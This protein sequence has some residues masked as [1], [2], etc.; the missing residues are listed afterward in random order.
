MMDSRTVGLAGRSGPRQTLAIGDSAGNA[1]LSFAVAEYLRLQYPRWPARQV[2]VQKLLRVG[3]SQ[4]KEILGG[5]SLTI[6]QYEELLARFGDDFVL[7]IHRSTVSGL[8]SRIAQL[9]AA[10]RQAGYEV[11]LRQDADAPD[12]DELLARY[13]DA[14]PRGLLERLG[15]RL[16]SW[17]GGR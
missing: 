17:W 10:L 15:R 1:G 3:L 9:E 12:I 6:A 16:R 13:R 8:V 7:H 5:R 14:R 2:G 4:A 11:P